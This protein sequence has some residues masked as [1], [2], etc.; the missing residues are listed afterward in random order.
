[1]HCL[2]KYD[3]IFIYVDVTVVGIFIRVLCYFCFLLEVGTHDV[4]AP[5]V[6]MAYFLHHE[7]IVSFLTA[8][9]ACN[10]LGVCPALAQI[11]DLRRERRL[12]LVVMSCGRTRLASR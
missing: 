2:A 11:E 8:L 9:S 12:K 6:E 7:L 3:F 4:V 10:L 1:M 5:F